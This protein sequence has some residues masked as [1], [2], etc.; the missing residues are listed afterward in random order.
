M[1]SDHPEPVIRSWIAGFSIALLAVLV[2]VLSVS[3][4][5]VKFT[6][7]TLTSSEKRTISAVVVG[8]SIRISDPFVLHSNR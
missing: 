4:E 7:R 8:R 5:R 1:E 6:Q 3:S 2:P